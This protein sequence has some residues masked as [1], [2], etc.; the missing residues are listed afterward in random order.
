MNLDEYITRLQYL[1]DEVGGNVKVY[2]ASHGRVATPASDP[3]IANLHRD[4]TVARLERFYSPY[5]HPS[6]DEKGEQ[7]I[8]I[9]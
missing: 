3:Q 7:V 4:H 2:A 5:R 9:G 1:R 6:L 8:R